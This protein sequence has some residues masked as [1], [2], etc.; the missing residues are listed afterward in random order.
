MSEV[1][2]KALARWR[3]EADQRVATHNELRVS[4]RPP[5]TADECEETLRTSAAMG[6]ARLEQGWH[7]REALK[8]MASLSGLI[9][10]LTER[11]WRYLENRAQVEA[12]LTELA[13][14]RVEKAREAC[15]PLKRAAAAPRDR[16]VELT[17]FGFRP[18]RR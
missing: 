8:Y 6:L 7:E 12:Y 10:P 17:I 2:D 4:G 3:E 1:V 16:G 15:R 14:D 9:D 13:G 5:R 18:R 11:S